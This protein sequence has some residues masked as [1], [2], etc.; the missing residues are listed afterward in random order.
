VCVLEEFRRL[1]RLLDERPS[2]SPESANQ[3]LRKELADRG[4]LQSQPP[5]GK[6]LEQF[7]QWQPI[8]VEGKPLSETIIEERR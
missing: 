1:R 8:A 4:L 3:R 7:R 2:Q 6:G 5:A